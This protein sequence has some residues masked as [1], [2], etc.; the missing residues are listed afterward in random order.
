MREVEIEGYQ[1]ESV[2]YDHRLG[3]VYDAVD[4]SRQR[5]ADLLV[6]GASL[7]RIPRFEERLFSAVSSARGLGVEASG[8]ASVYEAGNRSG[9]LF[10]ARAPLPGKG[11]DAV[12]KSWERRGE[13]LP[14]GTVPKLMLAA[15]TRLDQLHGS[16]VVHG[17]LTLQALRLVP[18]AGLHLTDLG[19][20]LL[21]AADAGQIPELAAA[22]LPFLSP[23][24]MLGG[25]TRAATD[26][27]ALGVIAYYLATGRMPRPLRALKEGGVTAYWAQ[28][29]QLLHE[30]R[31]DVAPRTSAIVHKALS[32]KPQHRFDSAR[33]VVDALRDV[34][35]R[36]PDSDDLPATH[37]L[38]AQPARRTS[39]S[40][41]KASASIAVAANARDLRVR[42]GESGSVLLM[43]T[44][45]GGKDE[46][47]V[48]EVRGIPRLWLV[49]PLEPLHLRPG[50]KAEVDVTIAVPP[51]SDAE[52]GDHDFMIEVRGTT[53]DWEPV[54]LVCTLNILPFYDLLVE[55]EPKYIRQGQSVAVTLRNHGNQPLTVTVR[56]EEE[57]ELLEFS[58]QREDFQLR[59]GVTEVVAVRVSAREQ[60]FLGRARDIP[61]AIS[62]RSEE[63]LS[64]T[65]HAAVGVTPVV[66]V[67]FA[68]LI[69]VGLLAACIG[70]GFLL[71]PGVLSTSGQIAATSAQRPT[72]E[73]ATAAA[74]AGAAATAEQAASATTTSIPAT[75]TLPTVT[76]T[77]RAT[78]SAEAQAAA[79]AAT[80]T[81]TGTPTPTATRAA[82]RTPTATATS[83]PTVTATPMRSPQ[84]A[85][86]IALQVTTGGE[87][88][89][90]AVARDGSEQRFL[91]DGTQ[92]TWSPD[93]QRLAIVEAVE[94]SAPDSDRIRVVDA[95]GAGETILYEGRRIG[96][97]SWSPDGSRLAFHALTQSASGSTSFQIFL[98]SGDGSEVTQLTDDAGGF[99]NTWPK[100]S[101]DGSQLIIFSLPQSN[102][103]RGLLRLLAPGAASAVV[104]YEHV[105][106]SPFPGEYDWSPD[107]ERVVFAT[108]SPE[109]PAQLDVVDVADRHVVA[110]LSGPSSARKPQWS[111]EGDRI[112]FISGS[113]TGEAVE[114]L[115]LED[116]EPAVIAGGLP[117]NQVFWSPT[118]DEVGIVGDFNGDDR[119]QL[120]IFAA[121][122]SGLHPLVDDARDLSGPAGE[123]IHVVSAD[124]RPL[125]P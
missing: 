109:E 54:V 59:A 81:A 103:A 76:A 66:P 119:F 43:V 23:E 12:A 9:T 111:P 8:I 16:G 50:G 69:L 125:N 31:P 38:K 40:R 115:S 85:N 104:L 41:P 3:V 82:T 112:L 79:S 117:I 19:L 1:I 37:R 51:N 95:E 86:E 53:G 20:P 101:P 116:R 62:V 13:Y 26:V 123:D 113:V 68:G 75:A 30:L 35:A 46:S 65:M 78:P 6:F 99:N 2:R 27:F 24:Q 124:W 120:F 118:G 84:T 87:G 39:E 110:L 114:A 92:P 18:G 32:L 60:P 17:N 70:L 72:A 96:G 61:F 71:R 29:P 56:G 45:R 42:P 74:P 11:L 15:A 49:A 77:P 33:Q 52:F 44:N 58:G 25:E 21:N 63:G 5:R 91:I 107:G 102:P 48:V 89:I 105:A 90:W 4:L 98:V 121:D 97:I 22:I 106:N 100:W 36:L 73:T 55:V 14:A 122:G 7:R 67:W 83:S 93:G 10:L 108:A 88:Q 80:P 64:E 28:T 57:G 47:L 34:V 94:Q